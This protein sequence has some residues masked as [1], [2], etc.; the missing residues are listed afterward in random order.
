VSTRR[1][2]LAAATLAPLRPQSGGAGRKFHAGAA[3]VNITPPLGAQIAGN[4]T[5]APAAEIHDELHVKSLVLDNGRTRLAFAVVDSCMVPGDIIAKARRMVEE[6]TGIPPAKV[7]VSATHTHS[8]PAA[9][10]LFQSR[11]DP[12][13]VD[14]LAVRIADSVRLAV[15]RL[16]PA[17]IG[18]GIGREERL[19]FCR[20][21]YMKPG[22]IPPNPLGGTTD[23]VQMNP[24]S[25]SPNILR[26]EGPI[27]PDVGVIAVESVQGRPICVIGNYALHY[28]GG[29]GRG[30]ISADYFAYWAQAMARQ[31]GVSA[32]SGFPPFVG[33]L[34]NACSG[35]GVSTNH[36][37]AQ[38]RYPPYV[39]M[40]WVAGVLAA[41]A[42]R[43]WRT[44]QFHDWV[45]LDATEEELEFAVRLPGRADV[46]EAHK[47]LAAAGWSMGSKEQVT[48]RR[49]IYARE[50]V[51]LADYP[52]TVKTPVQAL[53]IGALGLATFPGEAFAELGLE[54]KAKSPF[55]PTMLIELANDYRGYI[56]TPEAHAN[57][58]YETWR[59]KSSYLEVNAAPRMVAS[60]V[61]QL[62]KLK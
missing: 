15:E 5:F 37:V 31:A 48:D 40:E 51:F 60:A 55:Q 50:T 62:E 27:D 8:A 57:G 45:E 52:Q 26:P 20:R 56:P 32:S 11:P 30:H 10:H 1:D 41:E 59:A 46:A 58:G 38:K 24:P 42:Y 47:I 17:R 9:T 34:T 33:I 54:V 16:E 29:V 18:W 21:F 61:R 28:V 53:R 6:H 43:T 7:M 25:G 23:R 13:Y 35:Q 4:M 3:A 44:I 39:K 49:A 2:F 19:L 22:T 12:K 14:W 36:R